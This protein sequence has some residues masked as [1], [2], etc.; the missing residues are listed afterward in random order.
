MKKNLTRRETMRISLGAACASALAGCAPLTRLGNASPQ[1]YLTEEPAELL[2][3][4]RT[5]VAL[6]TQGTFTTVDPQG[7]PRSRPMAV[8]M[9]P[10]GTTFWMSTRPASRKLEQIAE[11]YQASLHFIDS[12]QWGYATFVG[13]ARAHADAD[14]I[15]KQSFFPDEMRQRLFPDFPRDMVMIEF[16]P[17]W[18]EVAGRGVDV[19]PETWQPQGARIR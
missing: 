17:R 7:R 8:N 11:N 18:L 14:T 12:E 9:P 1:L 4:A 15:R 13:E 6:Q 3:V 16:Q 10:G 5:V 2:A 19:H